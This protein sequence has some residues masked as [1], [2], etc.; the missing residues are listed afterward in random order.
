SEFGFRASDLPLRAS[1][2]AY[3][4]YTSGTTGKPKGTLIEHR[5]VVRLMI[6]DNYMFAF[7]SDDVWTMFHSYCFDFSVW[8]M[9]GALLYGGKLLVI[10]E[11]TAKNAMLYLDILKK[12]KVTVLNQTPPAFFNLAQLE[13]QHPE[14]ELKLKY[15]IFGGDVLK[16]GKLKKWKEKYPE[17]R[18]VNMFG[19]TETTVHVTFKELYAADIAAGMSNIGR[20]IPTLSV[21]VMDGNRKLTPVGVQGELHVGGDGVARGY[22]NRPELT[23]ERF[24]E[25]PYNPGQTLY[26]SGDLGRTTE[27]G[28]LHYIG[29]IDH[30]VK[31]RGYRIELEEIENNILKHPE[32]KEAVVLNRET[33]DGGNYLCAYY[34][35][36]DRTQEAGPG[37]RP[38]LAQNLPD[39]M[40]PSFFIKLEKIPLTI[41]GKIDKKTLAKI[42]L[43]KLKTR[44]TIAPRNTIDE[45]LTEI[46]AGI[47]EI[48]KEVIGIDDNFFDI[49]GH[50][51]RATIMVSKIHKQFNA[52]LPLQ[53][54]FKN[55]FI[56]TLSDTIKEFRQEKYVAIEPA[57][58]KETYILSS[59][60]KRL[61]VLQ[62]MEP[63]STAYNMPYIIPLDKDTDPKKLA[64]VFR[65]L[66]QR[67]ESLRTSFHM[68]PVTPGGGNPVTPGGGNPVTPGGVLPVQKLHDEVDFEIEYYKPGAGGQEPGTFFRPFELTKAPLL[69]VGI[70]ETTGM[71][72]PLQDGITHDGVMMLDMHHII[73]DGISQEVLIKEYYA[74]VAGESLPPLRLQYKDYAEWQNSGKQKE[75]LKQQEET[76]KNLFS[77]ELPILSLPTD[78]PRP[79]IQNFEG[80][81]LSFILSE[82][83]NTN[84]KAAAKENEVTLYMTILSIFTILLSKL[85]GQEDII[86]GTPTAGRRHADLEKI[87]GMF[88]N[89]LPMRNYPEG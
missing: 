34:V 49:G 72:P 61:Y 69:R 43:S 37:L 18:L 89:T 20:P 14:K 75:L 11:N 10:N 4:I 79:E 31:I 2:I 7:D 53:E 74:I 40:I 13:L 67:H 54:I 26:K 68:I 55:P 5:N 36:R 1:G 70:I 27:N 45:Q 28:E 77:G 80:Q 6:N 87:I 16:P 32:I 88:V 44:T 24:V 21:Y 59:A 71:E 39:Y 3:V 51:L 38:Y 73:T 76:W 66:I 35:D 56:R 83:K 84:L 62:Q 57:E 12:E 8:E 33:G 48:Q 29:R 42:Q 82:E 78:Y 86:V 52:K 41:N 15:V 22:L 47:L 9:Y 17:T 30:Q 25:N 23:H 60:Q 63:A 85:S 81:Y 19:I 46:W 64:S 50:S 65:Q 58:K